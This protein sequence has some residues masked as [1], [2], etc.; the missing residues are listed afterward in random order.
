MN[1]KSY[2]CIRAAIRN[3]T[4]KTMKKNLIYSV[5]FLL[6]GTFF[7]SSCEDMLNVDSNRV[8]YEF[9]DWTFN[10]SVY[11]VLGILKSVQ[12]IGD[13]HVLLNEL[14]GDLLSTNERTL[15]DEYAI[16]NYEFDV[17]NN[18]Y[19]DARLETSPKPAFFA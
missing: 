17:T 4:N 19:L 14:R 12:K 11:S 6:C 8:E 15:D 10:D 16:S 3:K 5:I 13:R 9:D 7:F 18:K 1:I 2:C